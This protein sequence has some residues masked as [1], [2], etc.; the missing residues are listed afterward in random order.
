[1][2]VVTDSQ[3]GHPG[4]AVRNGAHV[5]GDGATIYLAC[6]DYPAPCGGNGTW[7]RLENGGEFD[8]APPSVEEYA[9]LSIFA[10]KGNTRSIELLGGVTLEGAVYA[11]S[12]PLFVNS[13]D[14]VQI[15]ALVAVDRLLKANTGQ[16]VVDY[17]PA[18]PLIGIGRPVLIR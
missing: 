3:P 12:A 7:F 5:K 17:D 6:Q 1:V 9:G 18:S 11:A 13:P 10:D 14:L 2:Y 4:F 16:L 15:N 8:V